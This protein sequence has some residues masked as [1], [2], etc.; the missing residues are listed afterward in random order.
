[1]KSITTVSSK[2]PSAFIAEFLT[3]IAIG[4]KISIRK[5]R[6]FLFL[7]FISLFQVFGGTLNAQII[8]PTM[9]F[10]EIAMA[11]IGATVV[12]DV[13]TNCDMIEDPNGVIKAVA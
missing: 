12:D 10:P 13:V 8:S 1:M 4:V 5:A 6:A 2:G 3:P 11:S 7:A 9:G